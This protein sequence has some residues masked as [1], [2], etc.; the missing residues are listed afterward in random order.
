MAR[1][2]AMVPPLD[3]PRTRVR[4]RLLAV[5]AAVAL[6]G[7]VAG[8]GLRFETPAQVAPTPGANEIARQRAS[9]DSLGLAV[10]ADAP[11]ADPADPLTPVRAAVVAQAR[12]HLEQLGAGDSTPA[13]DTSP[14]G[15]PSPAESSAAGSSPVE[16]SP[17]VP[18]TAAPTGAAPDV[19]VAQLALAAGSARADAASVPDGPLARLLGSVS[20]ARILAARQ[21]AGAAALEPPALPPA[22]VPATAPAG[23]SPS[24]LR[25]VV[26][27]EDEA[28]YG[29]EVIAAKLSGGA[30]TSA[31]DRAAVHR[32]RADGW[33]ALLS[34]AHTGLDPRRSA[35]ALPAGLDDPAVATALAQTL[36][37]SLASTYASLVADAEPASRAGLLDALTDAAATAVAWGAPVP[38]V[39]GL[40]ERSVG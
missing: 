32:T 3:S 15:E 40:P 23:P 34:I 31:L 7:L 30:R 17:V 1:S 2:R 4:S 20:T 24:A 38:S 11:A 9:A 14:T 29:Y 12:A 5:A 26:A 18:P 37:L 25:A 27:A 13:S 6:A 22:A 36:E 21:L 33:A 19:V 39:P 35:Y 28:G 10:L 16:P 8:C